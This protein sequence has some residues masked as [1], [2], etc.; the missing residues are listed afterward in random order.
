MSRNLL[1]AALI[2]VSIG[3]ALPVAAAQEAAA[4][5]GQSAPGAPRTVARLTTSRL[6]GVRPVATMIQGNALSSTNAQLANA[7]V[8]LRDA[9]FG[10]I[11][12]TELTDKTGLFTFRNVDPG[13]Y[14]VEMMGGDSTVLAASQ[15]LNVNAGE[16]ASAI[17]KLPL[18][19]PPFATMGANSTPTAALLGAVAAASGV[20]AVATTKPVSPNQ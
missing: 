15:L 8:R 14:I 17:V 7:V 2:L 18:G 11:V 9:R 10:R 4:P 3:T 6:F 5:A 1:F 16:V 20:I 13:T 19:A 12:G